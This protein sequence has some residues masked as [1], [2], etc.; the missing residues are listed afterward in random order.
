MT[1]W[2]DDQEVEVSI[3]ELK[4]TYS[5]EGAIEKRL[6]EAT[7]TRKQAHAD[8]T[9]LMERLAQDQAALETALDGLDDNLYQAVIPPPPAEL[10]KSNPERYLQHKEA[11]DQDQE[12]IAKAKQALEKALNDTKQQREERRQEYAKQAGQ[13]L[14]QEIPELGDPEKANPM[15][16][17]MAQTAKVYGYTDQEIQNALDPR[18]FMLVRDAMRYRE[19][20][21]KTKGRDP[22]VAK[23]QQQQKKVRRLRSGNTQAKTRARQMDKQQREIRERAKKSGKVQDVAATLLQPARR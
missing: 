13:I 12:R 19:L 8:A 2:V 16:Q 22:E 23:Q 10:K 11:Y 1:L 6:Q 14:V 4:K 9:M 3:G 15:F 18:M 7:E 20:T 21:D 17:R 5:G